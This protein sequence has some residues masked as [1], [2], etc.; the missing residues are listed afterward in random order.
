[1]IGD[2]LA[3]AEVITNVMSLTSTTE[4]TEEDVDHRVASLDIH[5]RT[6]RLPIKA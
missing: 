1:M 2:T 3:F 6:C 4:E 5:R